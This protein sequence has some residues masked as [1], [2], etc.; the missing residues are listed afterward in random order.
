MRLRTRPPLL[1]YLL[2]QVRAH[3]TQRKI[4]VYEV[5]K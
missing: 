1:T 4:P 3:M 2:R 5:S